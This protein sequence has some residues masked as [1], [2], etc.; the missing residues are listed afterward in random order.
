MMRLFP[1]LAAGLLLSCA[2]ARDTQPAD[3]LAFRS[4]RV[5]SQ[6]PLPDS[7]TPVSVKK[8]LSGWVQ[9][10][11]SSKPG[12]GK[13][14]NKGT[15][16][17]QVGEG[18]TAGAATKP[19]TMATGTGAVATDA[20]KAD[21]PVTTGDGNQAASSRKG[22]AV[23]GDGNTVSQPAGGWPWWKWL[24]LGTALGIALRQFGPWLWRLAVPRLLPRPG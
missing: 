13:F 21:A 12:A 6:N 11:V 17:Y 19:G 15:I 20:K 7:A 23:A 5:K 18:N 22:P 3:P 24:G 10:L 8:G 9:K 16:I 14:K 2:S 4:A 1:L